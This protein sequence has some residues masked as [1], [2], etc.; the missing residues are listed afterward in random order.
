VN[1]KRLNGCEKGCV[2]G[3][4]VLNERKACW[5]RECWGTGAQERSR[6]ATGQPRKEWN[7]KVGVSVSFGNAGS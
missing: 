3:N 4:L 2:A 5:I 7:C 6:G 1:A